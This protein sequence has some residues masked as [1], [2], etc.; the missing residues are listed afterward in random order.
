LCRVFFRSF[1]PFALLLAGARRKKTDAWSVF[2]PHSAVFNVG[3]DGPANDF[4]MLYFMQ[5]KTNN[6]S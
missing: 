5:Y 3:T 6:P 1:A 2:S 4:F